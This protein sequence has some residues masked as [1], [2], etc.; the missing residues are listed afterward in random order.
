MLHT[1]GMSRASTPTLSRRT[2]IQ[3]ALELMDRDGYAAFSMPKL[4]DVLGVR[5]PSLYH[6]FRDRAEIMTEV[7]KQVV[8]ETEMPRRDPDAPWTDYF[9]DLCV[10]FRRTLLRHRN[11]AP[12]LVQFLPRDVMTS[13]YETAAMLLNEVP[14][15]PL[16]SHVLIIDGL[17][18]ITIGTSL[19]ESGIEASPPSEA[20]AS[21]FSN[22]DPELQPQLATAVRKN[23][24]DADRLFVESI[25]AFLAGVERS[26]EQGRL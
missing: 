25:R 9:V 2:I 15:L 20:R 26:A 3:T 16:T 22:V 6:H 13:R 8:Q 10:N 21:V 24:L 12:V 5:T 23:E 14:H 17:E 7:A 1:L 4:G 11:A 18:K 19:I